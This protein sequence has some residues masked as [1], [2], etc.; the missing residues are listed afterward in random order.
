MWHPFWC[1]S[2]YSG[3]E[4]LCSDRNHVAS[5]R[6]SSVAASVPR[7]VVFE[8]RDACRYAEECRLIR[9]RRSR[10]PAE[11]FAEWLPCL[12]SASDCPRDPPPEG[13]NT[14]GRAGSHARPYAP[15]GGGGPDAP[16]SNPNLPRVWNPREVPDSRVKFSLKT[17]RPRSGQEARPHAERRDEKE[18]P[19]A[20]RSRLRLRRA[21]ACSGGF[22]HQKPPAIPARA[23]GRRA[24][25]GHAVSTL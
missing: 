20:E 13:S 11:G 22:S 12:L 9:G 7:A 23:R 10:P 17:K 18:E 14:F 24:Q 8:K 21:F 15:R 19:Q 5:A 3:R 16:A 25:P 1:D 6:V 4:S 2:Y